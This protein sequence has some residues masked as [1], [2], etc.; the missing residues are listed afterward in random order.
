[1]Q[2][3]SKIGSFERTPFCFRIEANGAQKSL[4]SFLGKMKRLAAKRLVWAFAAAAVVYNAV[5][6]IWTTMLTI[7]G[8]SSRVHLTYINADE[9]NQSTIRHPLYT[10][11]PIL[12][13]MADL[14]NPNATLLS[15]MLENSF[16]HP[17]I[18][19]LP[20]LNSAKYLL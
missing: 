17:M 13:P 18:N 16:Y 1:M 9:N 2:L 4:A 6:I 15:V 12:E 11:C 19:F 20:V 8:I 14:N 7:E 10:I 5:Q 3:T